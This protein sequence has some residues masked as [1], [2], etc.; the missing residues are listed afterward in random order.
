MVPA[1]LVVWL[2]LLMSAIWASGFEIRFELDRPTHTRCDGVLREGLHGTEFWP[3][4]HAAEGLT[5]GG[6][7]SEVVE[8]LK[9]K[10][11]SETDDQKRCGLARELVRAGDKSGISVLL[12]VLEDENDYGHTHAAESL[13][14]VFEAGDQRA[15]RRGLSQDHNLKFKMMCAGALYRAGDK[16]AIDPIRAILS[17]RNP[18]HAEVAAWLIGQIG[19][20]SD[21][22]RLKAELPR[23]S[24]PLAKAYFEHAL[25]MRGDPDGVSALRANL[26]SSDKIIRTYAANFAGDAGVTGAKARLIEILDDPWPDARIRAAQALLTLESSTVRK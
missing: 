12:R 5:I 17:H 26:S 16:S 4:M 20:Q 15:L 9:P 24:D 3:A 23:Q 18:R 6:R 8:F 10:L 25:A 1:R 14:K 7:G 11:A 22:A 2:S 13:F 21:I 19:D